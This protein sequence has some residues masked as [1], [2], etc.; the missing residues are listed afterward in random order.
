MVKKNEVLF[1]L[2]TGCF[3]LIAL[4]LN[5]TINASQPGAAEY[6][7]SAP[8]S[9]ILFKPADLGW[10]VEAYY[11]QSDES[12][13]LTNPQAVD[14]L[15]A[16]G[17]S[18]VDAANPKPVTEDMVHAIQTVAVYEDEGAAVSRF[19]FISEN[20]HYG[21]FPAEMVFE[22]RIPN[23]AGGCWEPLPGK[24]P[25]T[26]CRVLI[27]YG[28]YVTEASMVIVDSVTTVQDWQ[29]L[30]TVVQNRLIAFVEEESKNS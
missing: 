14:V 16:A 19:G 3:F 27:Q 21:S 4:A 20:T 8:M 12:L 26:E 24:V 10:P 9:P 18:F 17:K 2:I 6:V 15:Q 28:R 30:M 29:K 1:I 5:K 22:P 7:S 13:F 23:I 11:E 25:W